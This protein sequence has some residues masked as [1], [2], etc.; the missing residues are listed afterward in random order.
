MRHRR[1]IVRGVAWR[2]RPRRYP[3][4]MGH[5]LMGTHR[6][7]PKH[8]LG[9]GCH[10]SYRFPINYHCFR[11]IRRGSSAGSIATH[12][13][14]LSRAPRMGRERVSRARPSLKK[15]FPG[16]F[17][18]AQPEFAGKNFHRGV[19]FLTIKMLRHQPMHC[20]RPNQAVAHAAN[21]ASTSGPRGVP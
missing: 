13:L 17:R 5:C 4:R 7:N 10:R 12:R 19:S 14:G 20:R 2:W 9:G 1:C 15:N 6:R 21:A 3:H 18:V 11:Y 8:A 16:R